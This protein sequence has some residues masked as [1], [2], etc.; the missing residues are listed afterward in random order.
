MLFGI[1]AVLLLSQDN[2]TK[3]I[4][5]HRLSLSFKSLKINDKVITMGL[6]FSNWRKGDILNQRCTAFDC[7]ACYPKKNHLSA[8]YRGI[9]IDNVDFVW[10]LLDYL[11]VIALQVFTFS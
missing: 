3:F 10:L 6:V 4:N 7:A 1:L 5:V 11:I 2:I 9:Y 8:S